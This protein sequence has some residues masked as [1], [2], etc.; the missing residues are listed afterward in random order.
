MAR[1]LKKGGT[2]IITDCDEHAFAFCSDE[3]ADLWTGF[4]REAI[5][6]RFA[7]AALRDIT[8][9]PTRERVCVPL[10]SMT[11]ALTLAYL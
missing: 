7:E 6:A 11:T 1:I 4:R 5:N 2:L 10:K 3:Q 8:V 9:S